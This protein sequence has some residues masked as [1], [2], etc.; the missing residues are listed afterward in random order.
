MFGLAATV[1]ELACRILDSIRVIKDA[2][3]THACCSCIPLLL[4][5]K[6][7]KWESQ[8]EKLSGFAQNEPISNSS[9]YLVFL[10]H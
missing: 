9:L 8:P 3:N 10:C 6:F 4:A 1:A 5:L 7:Q 2:E